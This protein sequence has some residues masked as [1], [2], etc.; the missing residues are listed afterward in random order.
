VFEEQSYTCVHEHN[1][2]RSTD[3][4]SEALSIMSQH[5]F[6]PCRR[7]CVVALGVGTCSGSMV[8]EG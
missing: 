2:T 4:V 5:N 6:N 8:V 7:L 1:S 3:F